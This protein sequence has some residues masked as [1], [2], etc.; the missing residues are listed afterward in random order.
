MVLTNVSDITGG[1][2][3][4]AVYTTRLN[5][6]RLFYVVGVAPSNEFSTY[7]QIFNRSVSSIQLNDQYRTSRY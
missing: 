6:G 4:I 5:D 3:R 2:E 1:Q 7:R